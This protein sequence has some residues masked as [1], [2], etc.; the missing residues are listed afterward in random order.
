MAYA[1]I[2]SVLF[3]IYKAYDKAFDGADVVLPAVHP[4]VDM[5]LFPL[6]GSVFS[7]RFMCIYPW[8]IM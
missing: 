6:L 8:T 2:C 3:G 5:A 1:E 7:H 4:H